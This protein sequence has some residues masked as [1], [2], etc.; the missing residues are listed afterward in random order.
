[1]DRGSSIHNA[2]IPECYDFI[3]GYFLF[4]AGQ[5]EKHEQAGRPPT[6]PYDTDNFYQLVAYIVS[7][8]RAL[9]P[10]LKFTLF[11]ALKPA[12]VRTC[13]QTTTLSFN[14]AI[15]FLHHPVM[16]I[17]E[18][19]RLASTVSVFTLALLIRPPSSPE[20]RSDQHRWPDTSPIASTSCSYIRPP[21]SQD[22]QRYRKKISVIIE[23]LTVLPPLPPCHCR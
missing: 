6:V 2:T 10:F 7:N 14:P 21:L 3:K 23:K 20:P 1:M 16:G 18:D 8:H 15:E 22:C 5:I 19:G 9:L 4:L 13:H 12:V 17:G 11:A